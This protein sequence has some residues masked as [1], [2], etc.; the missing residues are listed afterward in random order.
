[1]KKKALLLCLIMWGTTTYAQQDTLVGRQEKR[2]EALEN[3]ASALRRIKI[4]GYIQTQWQHGEQDASLKVGAGNED[5]TRSFNRF[6]IRRGRV[7]VAYEQGLGSAVFQLDMTEKG[8]NIRDVYFQVK[9]PFHKTMALRG[10]I[11]DRPFGYEIGYSSSLRESPE[12]ST[13]FQTLFPDGRDVG[14]MLSWQPVQSSPWHFLK[15]EAGLFAGNG[16]EQETD[17]RKDFIA[18]IS[19][20][21]QVNETLLLGFGFSYYNGGVYQGTENVYR[22]QGNGFVLDND[23]GN[24]GKFA[25]REYFGFS[26]QLSWRTAW[27]QTRLRGEYIFG[28]QPGSQESSKSPNSSK[29]PAHDTYIRPFGGG[30]LIAI[31]DLPKLPLSLVVKY[32]H[33]DPN[34]RVSK[35]EIGV[36]QTGKADIAYHTWGAGMLWHIDKQTRLQ[37]YYE[38]IRNETSQ[39]LRGYTADRKDNVFTVR[40]QYMF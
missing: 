28:T 30:Y 8:V 12:R 2:I 27:G 10:G 14:A 4:S 39:Q 38:V 16:I 25:K 15:L 6:G 32:D 34:T 40:L 29:L 23:A 22:M 1:M 17:N 36:L 33:Y 13:I 20:R 3:V 19:A 11:F 7:K 24:Q 9:D 18:Q 5:R 35:N 31:Q 37:A 26:G 21:R